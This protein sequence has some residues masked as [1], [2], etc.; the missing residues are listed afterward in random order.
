MKR[1]PEGKTGLTG[2]LTRRLGWTRWIF[3]AVVFV[4]AVPLAARAQYLRIVTYNIEADVNKVTTPRDGLYTVLEAIGEQNLNGVLQP[5]DILALEETTSNAVTVAPIVTALNGYY[6]AGTYAMATYPGTEYNGSPTTGNGP[7]ALIYNTKTVQLISQGG[8]PGTPGASG[9]YVVN[10]EVLRYGFQAV[11]STTG[12]LFYLYVSHMKSSASGTVDVYQGDRNLEAQDIRADVGSLPAGTS[13]IYVGDFNLDG[14]AE[15][16]YQTLTASGTGQGIDPLNFPQNNAETWNGDYLGILTESAVALEYR[17]DIQFMTADIY[18]RTAAAALRYVPGSCRAFGNNGSTIYNKT[19]NTSANTSLNNLV[20][21]ITAS[22]ALQALT[23]GS[24]HL[25]EVADYVVPTPYT[26]WQL[27]HFTAAELASPAISGDLADP[28]GD[29]IPNL[30]EY[31]LNLDP[32]AARTTGLPTVGQTMLGGQQY[33]TLTYTQVMGA[34]GITYLPQASGDLS[35]WNG[36]SGYTVA[37][38]TT[39][40]ADGATQT[41]VVRDAVPLS[42][43]TRRFLRLQVSRP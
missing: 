23:T 8:V 36:G 21:P 31:A 43:A 40:N 38:S 27:A 30:L 39:A 5:I 35:T 34:T 16:A 33:L 6:G 2:G 26:N 25:P 14:S 41:V 12:T 42:G 28:D 1:A 7:N 13:A 32:R 29:G 11:G 24:D 22:S 15:P 17:D 9:G 20:G 37:V 10:R 18:N 19:I 3:A 4:S